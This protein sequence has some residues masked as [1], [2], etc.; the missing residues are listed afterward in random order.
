MNSEPPPRFISPSAEGEFFWKLGATGRLH[1]QRCNDCGRFNH[2]PGP[3]C[4]ICHSRDL[5][6]APVSG[7]GTIATFTIN[8]KEWI[9]G[10]EPP[11]VFALVEL[12]ED[13]TVRIGTNIIGCPN[14]D[15]TIG[16]P[17]KVEFEKNGE[18]FVPLFR[19]AKEI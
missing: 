2:P 6:P 5:A 11:Y 16:M 17:V 15:V 19:P 13:P 4:P 8:H 10:F 12:E 9:P 14:E 18:W 3:V 7:R 1:L